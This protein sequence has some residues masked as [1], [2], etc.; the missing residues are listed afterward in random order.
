MI[1][2]FSHIQKGKVTVTLYRGETVASIKGVLADILLETV[3][4]DV[5]MGS[6]RTGLLHKTRKQPSTMLR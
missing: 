2:K 3:V 1:C 4:S 5:Q 6:L